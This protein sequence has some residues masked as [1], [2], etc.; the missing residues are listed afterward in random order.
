MTNTVSPLPSHSLRDEKLAITRLVETLRQEQEL[1][2]GNGEVE[3]IPTVIGEK[4]DIIAAM[5]T[6][7]DR[8]HNAL[9]L[10]GYSANE[11]GMQGWIEQHGTEQDRQNW[12]AV[13]TLAQS[14]REL[15]RLNGMLVGKQMA[16]NQAALNLLQGKTHG[17]FYGPNGQSNVRTSGRALGIG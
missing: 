9:D 7:A 5:A 15:N 8:R 2:S 10:L 1:L 4:A 6:L 14:A 11:D 12:D 13:F 17:T 16:L 3:Q